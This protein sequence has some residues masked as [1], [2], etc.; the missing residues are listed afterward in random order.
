VAS[1]VVYT[2]ITNGHAQL[3][4]HPDSPDTDFICFSDVPLDRTDWQIRPIESSPELS[5]RMRAKFHKIFPPQGYE[6]SVWMDG[7]HVMN[8]ASPSRMVDEMIAASPTGFGLHKHPRIDCLYAEGKDVVSLLKVR[9]PPIAEQVQHYR[10]MGHPEN[11]G[12]W[13][14]GSLCRNQN[15]RVADAMKMWWDEL[16]RWSD[17]DQISLSFVMRAIGFRPDDW[18]WKLYENP[19]F[20]AINHNWSS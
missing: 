1:R 17:R 7:S 14:C 9:D 12:L 20:S 15:P 8:M 4:A 6:W 3:C 16:L 13:A 10:R 18:P 2:A 19:H 5:P 11:W